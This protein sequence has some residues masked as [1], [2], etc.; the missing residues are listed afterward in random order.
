MKKLFNKFKKWEL[1]WIPVSLTLITGAWFL[2]FFL[3]PVSLRDG[4]VWQIVYFVAT[5]TG[6][7]CVV[8]TSGKR[9]FQ[10]VVGL[11]NILGFVALYWR[12]QLYGNFA[13]NLLFYIPASIIGIIL[14]LKNRDTKQTT[15]VRQLSSK[16]KYVLGISAIV[17]LI[18]FAFPLSYI[19]QGAGQIWTLVGFLDS[20]GTVLGVIGQVLLNLRYTEQW[21]IWIILDIIMIALNLVIGQ[22]AMAIMYALWTA[23]AIIGL[24]VWKKSSKQNISENV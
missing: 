23:N 8:L 17:S 2:E 20:A 7:L 10:W 15:Q 5:F 14:W 3:T 22:Y 24:I 13:L 16:N 19:N 9:W 6:M 4:F 11:V 12:W 18:I 1:V 21:W